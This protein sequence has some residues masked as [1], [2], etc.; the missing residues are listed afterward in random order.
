[1]LEEFLSYFET[2]SNIMLD[3]SFNSKIF[4]DRKIGFKL[5]DAPSRIF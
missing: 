5:T 4:R 2:E 3:M 1:M